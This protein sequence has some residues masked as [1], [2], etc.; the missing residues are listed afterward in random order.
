[1]RKQSF[2]TIMYSVVIHPDD[3]TWAMKGIVLNKINRHQ[4]ASICFDKALSINPQNNATALTMQ[5]SNQ[6]KY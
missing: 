3:S 5:K 6:E 1:M 2:V 4:E